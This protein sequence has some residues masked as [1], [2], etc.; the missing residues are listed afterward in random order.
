MLGVKI[1]NLAERVAELKERGLFPR[2]Q[3]QR[4]RVPAVCR[5]ARG[6]LGW[7]LRLLCGCKVQD[8]CFM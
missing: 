8:T 3:G 6:G 2:L 5:T 4:L 1:L 7:S